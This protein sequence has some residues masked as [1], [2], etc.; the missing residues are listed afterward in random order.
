MKDS[1][2]I[3]GKPTS[4]GLRT[5]WRQVYARRGGTNLARLETAP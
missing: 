2:S 1:E 4:G 3:F 5:D